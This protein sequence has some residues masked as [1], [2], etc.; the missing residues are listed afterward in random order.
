MPAM[1]RRI[2]LSLAVLV[3]AGCDKRAEFPAG[4]GHSVP[5]GR[6]AT[7]IVQALRGAPGAVA[8]PGGAALSTCVATALSDANIQIVGAA[9]TEAAERPARP[10]GRFGRGALGLAWLPA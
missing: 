8:L 10:A 5:T 3:L 7:L 1:P 2:A 4:C 6:Q 9:Y